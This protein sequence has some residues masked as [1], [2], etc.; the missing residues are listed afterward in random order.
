[1]LKTMPMKFPFLTTYFVC[2]FSPIQLTHQRTTNAPVR[3]TE[4]RNWQ[5][6]H[7]FNAL[8][9]EA[10]AHKRKTLKSQRRAAFEQLRRLAI[11]GTAGEIAEA[12]LALTHSHLYKIHDGHVAEILR[13]LEVEAQTAVRTKD[14]NNDK[15][16]SS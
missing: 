2:F 15:I 9:N 5:N 14:K 4:I 7:R 8:F 3:C 11:Y 12:Q 1:M 10:T 16:K 6:E 13:I